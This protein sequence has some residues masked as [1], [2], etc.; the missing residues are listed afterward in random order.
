MSDK[1]ITI[2]SIAAL[3]ILL[4]ISSVT[5]SPIALAA[6]PKKSGDHQGY[7]GLD[8]ADQSVHKGA[9]FFSKGDV[10]FHT[11]TGQGGF[12]VSRVCPSR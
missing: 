4:A 8:K 10:E 2:A 5:W 7:Q 11:G 12:C 1:T 3:A 9:G 6:A